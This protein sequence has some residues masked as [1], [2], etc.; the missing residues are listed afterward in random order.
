MPQAG[1]GSHFTAG[2][3]EASRAFAAG[4]FLALIMRCTTFSLYVID[5]SEFTSHLRGSSAKHTVEHEAAKPK[6]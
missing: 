5:L 6:A 3:G 1:M 2:L 4:P